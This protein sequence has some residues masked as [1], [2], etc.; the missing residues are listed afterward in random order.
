MQLL[1]HGKTLESTEDIGR[2]AEGHS[3]FNLKLN[4]VI[5]IAQKVADE[6]L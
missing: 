5:R 6:T 1:M 3:V 2:C 4:T